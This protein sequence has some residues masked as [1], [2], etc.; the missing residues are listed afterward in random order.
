[1]EGDPRAQGA[2]PPTRPKFEF[3]TPP[4]ALPIRRPRAITVS[5]ALWLAAA[6]LYLVAVALPLLGIGDFQGDVLAIVERDYPNE[7]AATRGRVVVLTSAVL[8]GGGM[9]LAL[10]EAGFAA[11]MRSGR[12]WARGVLVLLLAPQLL[13]AWVL[14]G[15]ASPASI[16][17]VA[18]GTALALAAAAAMFSP[19]MGGWLARQVRP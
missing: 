10:L 9:L 7:T 16:G 13:H 17:C 3:R 1:M 18:I 8:I 14:V 11:A 5:W 2:G 19:G 12:G 15:V 6:L 4:S